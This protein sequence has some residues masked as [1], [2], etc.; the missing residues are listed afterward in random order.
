MTLGKKPSTVQEHWKPRNGLNHCLGWGITASK[1]WT[2]CDLYQSGTESFEA[3][4]VDWELVLKFQPGCRKET[5]SWLKPVNQR[6][7][8]LGTKWGLS[9]SSPVNTLIHYGTLRC[10][11]I[12]SWRRLAQG[13]KTEPNPHRPIETNSTDLHPGKKKRVRAIT[14]KLH[15]HYPFVGG[16]HF[17][18]CTSS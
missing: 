11:S 3:V 1:T 8:T 6:Q 9:L 12:D 7:M 4:S 14:F 5:C 15:N 18:S 2:P 10:Y 16:L 13:R 17:T